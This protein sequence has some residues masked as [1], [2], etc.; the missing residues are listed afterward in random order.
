[1]A[2]PALTDNRWLRLV[3]FAGLYAAQGF[4]WGIFIVAIPTWLASQ[5]HS[6]TEVGLFIATVALPWTFKLFAGPVMDRFTFPSLGRRRPW[7][8][9][10]Q[11]VILVGCL[12]LA[13]GGT[14]FTWLLVVGIIVNAGAAVQ[15]VAVD[16]MAIDILPEAERARANS[17]MY[18]G[19]VAGISG[20]SSGGAY[21]LS[22]YGVGVTGLSLALMVATIA[23]IPILLRERPG[24]KLLPWTNGQALERTLAM[25]ETR[26]RRIFVDLFKVVI[27]PMS[28]L[29]IFV[30]VGDRTAVGIIT[31]AFPVLTT[32]ELGHPETFYPEWSALAGIFAA[33]FGIAVAPII[34][35]VTAQ[36]ALLLGLATKVV[37]MVAIG[38]L[39]EYWSD[40]RVLIGLLFL[41]AFISQWLTISSI[42]LFMHL[43]AV[44]V[45]ASQFAVYMAVSNLALSLGSSLFGPLDSWLDYDE[46]IYMVA[47]IDFFVLITL[48]F[49]SLEKHQKRLEAF[50]PGFAA[51]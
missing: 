21:L 22:S 29:L 11:L 17:F 15:D 14:N 10:A 44:K 50:G 32:Q 30:K 47:L 20:S 35:R 31:A 49:F 45:S 7:V 48:L 16:G 34:D 6:S 3:A 27:L 23:L 37:A 24:E 19:Q 18:G 9:I 12:M 1:M 26:W 4:P 42:S 51:N 39:I 28:L 8:I 2:L 41:I 36:R 5:G 40:D 13:A 46:M 38:L 43:C 25:Q 33:V